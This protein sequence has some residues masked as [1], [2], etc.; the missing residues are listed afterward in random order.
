M[1]AVIFTKRFIY[2]FFFFLIKNKLNFFLRLFLAYV[3]LQ[4]LV[5][6]DPHYCS[7]VRFR[8]HTHPQAGGQRLGWPTSYWL[9]DRG[10]AFVRPNGQQGKTYMYVYS[11]CVLVK[12]S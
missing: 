12:V 9:T 5:N 11:M 2:A 8:V 7:N 10:L 6:L 3:L 4:L 1:T